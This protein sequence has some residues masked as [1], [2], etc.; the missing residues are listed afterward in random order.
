LHE[1]RDKG[2]LTVKFISGDENEADIYEDNSS[3]MFNKHILKFIGI[4]KERRMDP[5][6]PQ[7]REGIVSR[8]HLQF[9]FV[10]LFKLNDQCV[11]FC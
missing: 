8:S 3:S 5:P 9:L 11:I 7:D 4:N 6:E 1:L 2:L 10:L